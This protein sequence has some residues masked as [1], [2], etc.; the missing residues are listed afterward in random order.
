MADNLQTMIADRLRSATKNRLK[1]LYVDQ[2]YDPAT[3]EALAIAEIS[4]RD[5]QQQAAQPAVGFEG[6]QGRSLEREIYRSDPRRLTAGQPA[7]QMDEFRETP[8]SAR[9]QAQFDPI[10]RRVQS[11][12]GEPV[13]QFSTPMTTE[14]VLA[15]RGAPAEAPFFRYDPER[16]S[17]AFNYERAT[18]PF[19]DI[20]SPSPPAATQAPAPTYGTERFPV[21]TP[22]RPESFGA[23]ANRLIDRAM[24]TVTG[25]PPAVTQ[26]AVQTINGQPVTPSAAP[27]RV[28][29]ADEY[30][31]TGPM[32]AYLQ[33]ALDA[34]RAA[35]AAPAAPAATARSAP[36]RR[37]PAPAA[38]S[39]APAASD[40]GGFFGNLFKDPY[41]GMSSQRLYEEY[42]KRGDDDPGMY[43]RAAARQLE[44]QRAASR[45]AEEQKDA[46]MARGGVAEGGKGGHHKDAVV[47]KALEIIHHMLR[48]R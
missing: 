12:T 48:G 3:A 24:T 7:P 32:G 31:F 26:P 2:G 43:A 34:S 46:G 25:A 9:E 23:S 21:P 5:R 18:R 29:E 42:Q 16:G 10:M 27:A 15:A 39:A 13:V 41:A 1:Q 17:V 40:R 47:M 44:E 22:A 6:E 28:E 20:L 14:D 35:P 33:S 8:P 30:G 45:Q 19:R 38:A 4:R 11:P 36:A 37:A